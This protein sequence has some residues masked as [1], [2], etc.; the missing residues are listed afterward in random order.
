MTVTCSDARRSVTETSRTPTKRAAPVSMV[1]VPDGVDVEA[2]LASVYDGSFGMAMPEWFARIMLEGVRATLDANPGGVNYIEQQFYAEDES[3]QTVRYTV[4]VG[5][6]KGKTPH[7]LRVAA[8]GRAADTA[9]LA[10]RILAR[11]T[12]A[13]RRDLDLTP[14]EQAVVVVHQLG[15][16]SGHDRARG[17]NEE[18][19]PEHQA[20]PA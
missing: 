8:D 5:R 2:T 6:P 10:R 16:G 4:T 12:P 11:L 9:A 3:G 14:E 18:D 17:D 15:T 19:A 20:S 13:R 7:E 1:D